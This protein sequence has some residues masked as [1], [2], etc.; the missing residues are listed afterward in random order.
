MYYNVFRYF[1][2]SYCTQI[3]TLGEVPVQVEVL[4]TKIPEIDNYST[5]TSIPAGISI[6]PVNMTLKLIYQDPSRF[7]RQ[8]FFTHSIGRTQIT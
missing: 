7:L 2:A 1:V 4:P 6:G 3:A 8:H 5:N